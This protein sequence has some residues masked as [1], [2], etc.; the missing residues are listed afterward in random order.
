MLG[1]IE[2]PKSMSTTY[3]RSDN[4]NIFA[5][6]RHY[7]EGSSYP[8]GGKAPIAVLLGIVD[9]RKQ[10]YVTDLPKLKKGDQFFHQ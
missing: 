7:V 8:T 10:N 6:E 4:G 9:S 1:V 3:I 2:I 5:K